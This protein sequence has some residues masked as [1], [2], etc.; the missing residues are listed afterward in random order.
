MATGALCHLYLS[1]KGIRALS[2]LPPTSPPPGLTPGLAAPS[3][4]WGPGRTAAAT[5]ALRPGAC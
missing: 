4:I 5:P 3:P 1:G 2:H